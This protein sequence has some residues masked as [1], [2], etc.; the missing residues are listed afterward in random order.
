MYL[1]KIDVLQLDYLPMGQ[2]AGRFERLLSV[3]FEHDLYFQSVGRGLAQTRNPL[4]RAV[5][6]FEY[7]RAIRYELNLL[8]QMDRVQVCTQANAGYLLSFRPDLKGRVDAGLR[9]GIDV[10]R[11][12]F[13]AD[14][15][16]PLTMLFLGS[17]RHTP[18]AQALQ[19]FVLHSLGHVLAR[20]PEARLVVIGSDPPPRHALPAHSHAIELRGFVEDIDEPLRTQAVFVCPIL[21]GSGV[22]VK[23]L[24]AFACGIPAVSTRVGAEGL[25]T[26]DGEFCC[27]ADDAREFAA[28]ILYL[29]ENPTEAAAMA[30]RARHE[31]ERNWD[32]EVR[33]QR[34][35]ASYRAALAEKRNDA[36]S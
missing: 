23:L 12:R 7:L 27:L 35:V 6:A 2:Y 17:F 19:W 25:A 22:R 10:A 18:N 1:H 4:R 31:V 36:R 13:T 29:F 15:R 5:A 8:P 14:G 24:E 16:Q 28:K 11:Y 33:T 3:L 9:A 20:K 34:L 30:L 21:S 32:M 26:Q